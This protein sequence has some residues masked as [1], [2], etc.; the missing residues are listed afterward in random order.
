LKTDGHTETPSQ[1]WISLNHSLKM[2]TN[3]V[4]FYIECIYTCVCDVTLGRPRRRWI[5]NIKIDILKIGLSVVDGIG[6]A[7]NRYRWRNL[8]NSVMNLRVQ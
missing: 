8:V 4:A 2:I 7:Q 6:L 1:F 3:K 5:Y